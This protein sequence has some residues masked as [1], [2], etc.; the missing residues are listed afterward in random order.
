ML[1]IVEKSK[2]WFS[3]SI[4]II[5]IGMASLVIQG[6]NFGLEFTGGTMMSVR[7]GKEF[8]IEDVRKVAAKY[9][10]QAQVQEVQGYEV[11]I[12]SNSLNDKEI[13]ELF[14]D[15][16]DKYQ[17]KDDA[18]RNTERIEASVGNELKRNAMLSSLVAVIGI[19]LY[20]S[21]RFEF[22]SGV[23]SVIALLHDILITVSVYSLLQIPVN[24]S[25][26]AAILTILGYS[27]NDTIVVFDRIRENKKTGKY[28][29]FSNL[30]NASITET[31]ARSINTVL[32]TLFTITAIYILGVPA[33]KEFALP[34]IIGIISGCYSSIFIAS[35]VWGLWV[36]KEQHA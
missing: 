25:F 14:K 11:S 7:I 15:L 21:Y 23:S 4:I 20:V 8:N 10:P 36:K 26:I 31:M 19:L 33:V 35:P 34:L 1:K 16:K 30:I 27:I 2:L 24:G 28:K 22:K 29:D 32:T 3:I 17:L 9:D 6:L 18:L 12:R 5:I 13:P